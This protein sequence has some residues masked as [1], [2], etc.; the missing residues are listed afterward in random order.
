M[1]LLEPYKVNGQNRV[2]NLQNPSEYQTRAN[3]WNEIRFQRIKESY[4]LS[5][6]A[7]LSVISS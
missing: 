4:H 1:I 2:S 7:Y 6:Y 3:P 5:R